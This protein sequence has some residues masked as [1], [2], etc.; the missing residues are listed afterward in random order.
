LVLEGYTHVSPIIRQWTNIA[1]IIIIIIIS[2]S[3]SINTGN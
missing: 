3:S 1:V 2:S